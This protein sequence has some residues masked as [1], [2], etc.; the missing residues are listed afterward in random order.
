[1]P[2][3]LQIKIRHLDEDHY[4]VT[5]IV[6]AIAFPTITRESVCVGEVLTRAEAQDLVDKQTILVTCFGGDPKA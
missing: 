1:M 2:A 3:N 6:G 4:I 5:E